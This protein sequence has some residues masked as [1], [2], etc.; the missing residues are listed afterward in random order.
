MKNG[1]A[2][3]ILDTFY[4]IVDVLNSLEMGPVNDQTEVLQFNIRQNV[5]NRLQVY[6][7]KER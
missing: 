7:P 3:V 1:K 6:L 4:N 5:N 2:D